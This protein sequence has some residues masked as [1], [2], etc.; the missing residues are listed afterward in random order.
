MNR[1]WIGSGQLDYGTV[2]LRVFDNPVAAHKFA[3]EVEGTLNYTFEDIK[4]FSV[5]IRE[6]E[7]ETNV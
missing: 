5:F 6:F 3:L 4:Y 2:V 7:V 1:V